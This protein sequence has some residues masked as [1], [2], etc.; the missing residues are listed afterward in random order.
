MEGGPSLFC[1]ALTAAGSAAEGVA[2]ARA[3]ELKNIRGPRRP[4]HMGA[5][6]LSA[7]GNEH[8]HECNSTGM[9]T[10][11][12]TTKVYTR[13]SSHPVLKEVS[14]NKP[15]THSTRGYPRAQRAPQ[16]FQSLFIGLMLP[17]RERPPVARTSNSSFA[18][19]PEEKNAHILITIP[20]GCTRTQKRQYRRRNCA[21]APA[22]QPSSSRIEPPLSRIRSSFVGRV[23]IIQ[24]PLNP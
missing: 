4:V 1:Q 9:R 3:G 17:R 16:R 5:E 15:H 10:S 2:L 12:A 24:Q 23:L 19:F 14:R 11:R 21:G 7:H 18:V 13:L 6:V 22:S 20:A 8:C